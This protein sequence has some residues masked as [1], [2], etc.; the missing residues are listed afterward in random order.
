MNIR[1]LFPLFVHFILGLC[2]FF[3]KQK[4]TPP[5]KTTKQNKTKKHNKTPFTRKVC[6][7]MDDGWSVSC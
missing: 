3:K 4:A 5:K 2:V 6:F 1:F 7:M